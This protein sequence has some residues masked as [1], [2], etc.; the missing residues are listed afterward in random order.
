MRQSVRVPA[1]D[2]P[3]SGFGASEGRGRA[4]AL[5]TSGERERV[6]ELVGLGIDTTLKLDVVAAIAQRAPETGRAESLAALCGVTTRE[7]LPTLEALA[8]VGLFELRRFYN[9][10]EYAFRPSEETRERLRAIVGVSPDETRRLRRGLLAREAR[11]T[12]T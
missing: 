5:T 12:L 6:E 3:Q 11:I 9:I 10:A 8:A 4:G 1:F 7:I 2:T